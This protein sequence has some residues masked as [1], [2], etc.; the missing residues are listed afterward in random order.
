MRQNS[1]SERLT[2]GNE[3]HV[4]Q[5]RLDREADALRQLEATLSSDEI[6]RAR[7]FHFE[8]DRNHYI[9]GRGILRELLGKYLG[10]DPAALEF[11]YGEHGK[12]QLA[13]ANASS[14]LS[15]NLSHSGGLAVYAFAKERNLGIDVEQI[16][17]DFVSEDIARRYFSAHEVNDLLSLP[18]AD[19]TEAFFRCWTRKEA[20][21]K[22]RGAGLQIPLDSFS[23]SF[24][25]GQPAQ[26]LSGVDSSWQLVELDAGEGYAAALAYDGVPSGVRA[27]GRV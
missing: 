15:F 4:W 3:I 1:S 19:R 17:P 26:F 20:Y 22:A 27:M 5:A 2:I 6:A 25:P 16:R 13:G 23:V 21:I 18:V 9:V 24:L 11:S 8:R 7:R 10:Q 12:P 14:G